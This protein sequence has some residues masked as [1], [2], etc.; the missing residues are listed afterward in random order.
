MNA[1][2]N[3]DAMVGG[4]EQSQ[5]KLVGLNLLLKDVCM[6]GGGGGREPSFHSHCMNIW[7]SDLCSQHPQVGI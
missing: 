3:A 7:S 6:G 1:V 2:I 5:G 4:A